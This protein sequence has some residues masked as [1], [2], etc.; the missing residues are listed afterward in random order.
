MTGAASK[1]FTDL[2]SEAAGCTDGDDD[3]LDNPIMALE[4]AYMDAL[5]AT[6]S[7][8]VDGNGMRLE[9]P[10]SELVFARARVADDKGGGG[11]SLVE[12]ATGDV[13]WLEVGVIDG[14]PIEVPDGVRAVFV[15]N[16]AQ[17]S[18]QVACKGYAASPTIDGDR[19][20]MGE[21]EVGSEVCDER[22]EELQL[23][24]LGARSC[25]TGRSH[26]RQAHAP[27]GRRRAHLHDP[28]TARPPTGGV[29]RHELSV[30]GAGYPAIPGVISTLD[31]KRAPG[32]TGG[33]PGDA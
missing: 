33:S 26:R 23:T 15:V 18:G 2:A 24:Y 17:I 16:G 31:V 27:R 21:L 6:M 3:S 8:E 22:G 13:W 9:G 7:V 11:Q 19:L 28:G 12:A 32:L 5:S 1:S 20:R 10:T 29:I 30:E 14:V 4:R 25:D